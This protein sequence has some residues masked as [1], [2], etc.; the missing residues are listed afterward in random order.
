VDFGNLPGGVQIRCVTEPV[1]SGF[2][3]LKKAGFTYTG[4]QRFPGLLCRIDGKPADD[5]CVNAPP[6][7]RYWAYWTAPEPGR[8]WTYSDMGAGNRTPPPGSVEGWAFSDGCTRAP[9]GP[10]CPAPTTT[11][12]PPTTT[13][14]TAAGGSGGSI[15]A[16]DGSPNT[17]ARG[18]GTITTTTTAD[19]APGST[20]PS[21]V[22]KGGTAPEPGEEGDDQDGAAELAGAPTSE[23]GSSDGGSATG[24]VVGLAAA[25]GIGGAALWAARRR[26]ARQEPV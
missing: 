19:E 9:Q 24:A 16:G 5:P 26:R 8:K 12:R 20:T 21:E 25:A 2:D 3:A 7:D 17:T 23:G 14:T 6:P 13:T 18:V 10:P 1:T 4:A 15:D 22:S 11:T